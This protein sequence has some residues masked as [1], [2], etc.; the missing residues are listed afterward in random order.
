MDIANSI[1]DR[2]VALMKEAEDNKIIIDATYVKLTGEGYGFTMSTWSVITVCLPLPD[3]VVKY[4]EEYAKISVGKIIRPKNDY[5]GKNIG[6]VV[7]VTPFI[8]VSKDATLR[9]ELVD[10]NHDDFVVISVA[11]SEMLE[12]CMTRLNQ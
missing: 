4:A 10:V 11:P 8:V 5:I 12:L 2:L 9:H 1:K 6:V 3:E 7:S